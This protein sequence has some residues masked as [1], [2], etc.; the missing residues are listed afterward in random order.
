MKI[1]RTTKISKC[2]LCFNRDLLKLKSYGTFFV[3]NFV[4]QKNIKRGVKAPLALVYCKKCRLLQLQHS[5]PQA[6]MYRRFYWYRSGVTHTMR[7]AL[8]DIY[9]QVKKMSI[10]KKA[11]PSWIQALMTERYLNFLKKIILLPQGASPQKI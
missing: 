4:S 5:A 7:T 6:L 8:K 1:P 2:R 10:L 3:S 11:T 9:L